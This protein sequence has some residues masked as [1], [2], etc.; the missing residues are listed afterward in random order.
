MKSQRTLE[1]TSVQRTTKHPPVNPTNTRSQAER[2]RTISNISVIDQ[3]WPRSRTLVPAPAPPAV[4]VAVVS[5]VALLAALVATV[6]GVEGTAGRWTVEAERRGIPVESSTR[7]REPQITLTQ[8]PG[9]TEH[10]AL[11]PSK[12]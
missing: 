2:E 9:Q 12:D 5:I 11:V 8:R 3:R 1:K 6:T 10:T 7:T 4:A